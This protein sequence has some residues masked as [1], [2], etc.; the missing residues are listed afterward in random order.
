MGDPPTQ[1]FLDEFGH[2]LKREAVKTGL[3][4][5]AV[6]AATGMHILP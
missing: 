4:S 1:L 5:A 3:V 6:V 2:A